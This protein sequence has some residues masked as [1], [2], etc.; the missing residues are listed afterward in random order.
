MCAFLSRR[1]VLPGKGPPNTKEK[2]G[3]V[4]KYKRKGRWSN[5]SPTFKMSPI[6]FNLFDIFCQKSVLKITCCKAKVKCMR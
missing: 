5:R 2:F 4:L 6:F 3:Q 1:K